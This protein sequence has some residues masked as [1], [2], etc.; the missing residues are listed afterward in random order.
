MGFGRRLSVI[1]GELRETE[2]VIIKVSIFLPNREPRFGRRLRVS[3][4]DADKT[5]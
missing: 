2:V 1:V 4:F 5:G 3:S